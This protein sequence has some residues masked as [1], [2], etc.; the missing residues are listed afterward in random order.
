MSR[1]QALELTINKK[2]KS[3]LAGLLG[4]TNDKKGVAAGNI[5]YYELQTIYDIVKTRIFIMKTENFSFIMNILIQR[6]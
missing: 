6:L 2:G 3:R 4:F 1:D 5:I